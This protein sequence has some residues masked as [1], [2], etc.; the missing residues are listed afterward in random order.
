MVELFLREQADS[1][2]DGTAQGDVTV[3]KEEEAQLLIPC[4]TL[5]RV[6]F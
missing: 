5:P 1:A 6:A 3:Q 4:M 2:Q